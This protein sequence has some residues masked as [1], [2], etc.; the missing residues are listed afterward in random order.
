M[1]VSSSACA[2]RWGFF[3]FTIVGLILGA[4]ATTPAF[5]AN[6]LVFTQLPAYGRLG[7]QPRTATVQAEDG[8]GDPLSGVNQAISLT[9]TGP[10]GFTPL[11]IPSQLINGVATFILADTE[12]VQLYVP[13]TYTY[14]ATSSAFSPGIGTEIVPTNVYGFPAQP[15]NVPS[16]PLTVTFAFSYSD[17]SF[18][19]TIGAIN[20]LTEGFTG[21]D[22]QLAPGGTCVVG[23][24]YSEGKS[25]TVNLTF[26]PSAIGQ[27]LGAVLLYDNE[28]TP[29]LESVA[30]ISGVGS[31]GLVNFSTTQTAIG[32]GLSFPRFVAIDGQGDIYVAD[33]GNNRVVEV[34]AGGG[35]QTTLT[36]NAG[37][38]PLNGPEGL[39]LD[40]LGNLYIVDSSNNRIVVVPPGL[41][42]Q[43][44]LATTVNEVD[45]RGPEGLAIDRAG[46]LYIA[47]TGNGR[48]VQVPTSGVYG[49]TSATVGTGLNIPIGVAVDPAGNIF[50]LDTDPDTGNSR[51][52]EIAAVG[53]AQTVLNTTANGIATNSAYG[54]STDGAG[55][56]YIADYGNKRIVVVPLGGGTPTAVGTGLAVPYN[57]IADGKGDVYIADDY[58][59]QVVEVQQTQL[60]YI[61]SIGNDVALSN[62]IV[63]GTP[64]TGTLPFTN[65]GNATLTFS[66]LIS[67]TQFT[68]S[69]S[70]NGSVAV[71]ATCTLNLTFT[72]TVGSVTGTLLS[73]SISLSDNAPNSP[74]VIGLRAYGIQ[75]ATPPA[76]TT[77]PTNQMISLGQTATLSVVLTSASLPVTYQWYAGTSPSTL[78]AVTGA[79][80][81]S[82]TTPALTVTTYYSVHITNTLG[83][84][85]SATAV[86]SVPSPPTCTI[87]VT[88][89][90]G[91]TVNVVP[92]CTDPQNEPM[93]L[94]IDWFDGTTTTATNN[95]AATHTYSGPSCN[96]ITLTATDSGG[97]ST[98]V[99]QIMVLSPG[100]FAGIPD[101]PTA[102]I[103]VPTTI[104]TLSPTPTIGFI[105]NTVNKVINGITQAAQ[106]ASS[107]G[108]SCS[109]PIVP[110]SSSLPTFTVT[111]NTT[112]VTST[113]N[114][115]RPQVRFNSIAALGLLVPGLG[116]MGV[117]TL[118]G[119]S[120]KRRWN[121]LLIL[122]VGFFSVGLTSCGGHFTAPAISTSPGAAPTPVG[123]Y[124]VN[125]TPI[126]SCSGCTTS[127]PPSFLQTSLIVSLTV[128]SPTH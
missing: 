6:Q 88:N 3:T 2:R 93:T 110:L 45:L 103:S 28:P 7:A 124:L 64:G 5:A 101:T 100:V 13:G 82:F 97:A 22:F 54:I 95:V 104:Y 91:L 37:S 1:P 4:F 125:L 70:C 80:N 47:D 43:R 92:V 63:G 40:G 78:A 85:T 29:E 73:G 26:N 12:T 16:T 39:A 87:T 77:Q 69:D 19:T 76:I 51:V 108:I 9:I 126:T 105:C 60:P 30:Y 15:L 38:I 98:A 68:E 8:Q 23:N 115:V 50:I 106:S 128:A 32:T 57:A 90:F 79:T 58:N 41:G 62:G 46:N 89:P 123:A 14:T 31:G 27:R 11:T 113:S 86:V 35:Q 120:R 18:S 107:V 118:L 102:A 112:P 48:V 59:D 42:N 99:N 49:A 127:L 116:L 121:C 81:S 84:T 111:I 25:C 66:D 109:T 36:I 71:G 55:N 61:P 94:S 44:V 53:G 74:Q 34:P 83:T 65:I 67:A 56:L 33:Y 20:V 52:M 24:S 21:L 114:L 17:T 119:Y 117:G 10:S 75:V 72:P 96:L 122:L